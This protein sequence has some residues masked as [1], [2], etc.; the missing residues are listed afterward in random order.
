MNNLFKIAV[1][2]LSLFTVS[3]NLFSQDLIGGIA[4]EGTLELE[5]NNTGSS[6]NFQV[7]R[8]TDGVWV[9][10]WY[11]TGN[12]SF[13]LY[14]SSDGAHADGYYWTSG[15]GWDNIT[16]NRID[17]NNHET[18][19]SMTAGL[20][21]KRIIY[22]PANST[23]TQYRYEI[24]NNDV[25]TK[26]DLRFF[27]GG[28]TW[29]SGGDNGEGNWDAV[30]DVV[31]VSKTVT[32]T[33]Q[34]V[35]LNVQSES[36]ASYA[37]QSDFY[38]N[39]QNNIEAGSPALDNTVDVVSHDNAL[40]LEWRRDTLSAGVTWSIEVTEWF[41]SKLT[42]DLT[43]TAS[44]GDTISPCETKDITF[45]VE[46]TSGA[47]VSNISLG[48]LIDL[49]GW[50]A[51]VTSP[52]VPF[53]LLAG[54][55]Q[56]V[57]VSVTA[58]CAATVGQVAQNELTATGGVNVA[59][60][61]AYIT[62]VAGVPVP[63]VCGTVDFRADSN[64]DPYPAITPF[65]STMT[66]AD[67]WI[68]LT[69]V[70]SATAGNYILPALH[71]V[72]DAAADGDDRAKVFSGGSATVNSGTLL[73]DDV[74][75]NNFEF[76]YMLSQ[77]SPSDIYYIEVCNAGAGNPVDWE[78]F[79]GSS[80]VSLGSGTEG[81][82][83]G[84]R[85]FGPFSPIGSAT[86]ASDAPLASIAFTDAGYMSFDPALSGPGT[87]DF[88]YYW[89]DGNT[90]S[91]SATKTITVSSPHDA[92]WTNPGAIC[93]A[94]AAVNLDNEITGDAG[95]VFTGTG[96]SGTG[97]GP[98]PY[99]F[100]PS[101]GTQTVFYTVTTAV[102]CF[103]TMSHVLTVTPLNTAAAASSSPTL[104][105]NTAL[106]AITIATTGA[107][108]IANDGT[109][110]ANGLPAGVSA[111]WAGNTITIS[112]T[113]TTA[114]GSP[115]GYSILLT[116]GCGTVNATGT[117]TVTPDNTAAVASSSPSLCIN[118]ALTAI[119]IATTGATGIANDGV[120]GA[121]GLPAGVSAT[122]SGNTIT[123]SG[124][125]T[126]A[127]GS[128]FGYSIL[129]T[130]GCGTVNATG[131]ITVTPDNTAAAASSSPT[132]CVNTALTAIT[133]ATTGATGIANDGVAGANGL[134]AGVSANFSGNTITISGTP[135]TAVGSPFG[136][137]ILL[138]GGCGTVN[139]TGTITVT[140]DNT[141]GVAS[142]SPALCVN[143]AISPVVTIA[144]TG[145]T[146]IANDG[147]D[148][149]NGLPTGVSATFS[150]NT[151]TISGTPSTAVGSPFGYSILLTGGCGTVNAT[152]TITVTP[153]N[154]AAV[155]SSSPILC[156]NTALTAI[157][158]ATTG[159]TG[160]ANDGVAGANGLPAG[161]SA[162][163][164]GNTITI[165][166]T[167][168]TGVGS[169]FGYSILLT[170][171][172]GTVNAIGTITVTPDNTAGVASS[173]PALCVNTAISPAVTIATTG[174]TGIAND[175][176]D[177]ANG[178]PTGVSATFSGNTITISG[179]PSTDVGSPFGYS[180]L[181][182]GGCGTVNA[183][184]TI[185]VTTVNTAAAA[186]SSPTLCVNT[187]LT[188]ITIITAGATGIANDGVD[189]AN[190]LPAGVTATW[191]GNTITISGTPSTAIGS[192]FGYSILLTGGCGTANA[193]GTI[194][195]TNINTA[196]VASSSPTL[197][198]NTALTA[199]TIATTGAT[200]I[201]NDG[202][203]GANGLPAG[204]N[205]TF[206]GN[207]I[208][209]SGTPTTGVG[210]PFG[211]NILLT[212]GCGTVNAT[213]A[214]TVTPENTAGVASIS[215]T[216][217]V[218]TALTAIT[219]ATTGATGIA[220]DG[221]DGANGLPTGV[222]ATFSG[223]TITIS[224][225]PT[226]GVGS[227]FGYNILLTGG[228]GTVNATGT[229]TVTPENTAAAAS[230]SPNL[231][232]N[233][234]LTAI[235]IATT[236]ATGIANDGVDGANGLPAGVNATFS[237]N[238]ITISGTPTTGVGSP[239]GYNILLT[240][241]CGTVNATGTIT[242]TPE[243]TVG[244]ASSSPTLCVNTGLTA[245]TIAT[246]GVT[247]IA[248]D[249]VDGANGLPTGVSA[250]FSGNTI[251]ISGTPTTGVGSPFGYSILLTGGCGTVSA[252]G[253]IMVTPDNTAGVASSSPTLCVNTA[254][255]AITI[256]TTGATGI[257]NDG[258]DGAN[259]LPAGV[260]ATWFGG[261]I[262]IS[263][264]P[265]T[266][267]GSPFAYSIPLT[268]G[269]GS[270]NATGT[271]TV[272]PQLSI[273]A[274]ADEPFCLNKNIVLSATS[275]G[276]GT[277][278][279]YTDVLG[280]DKVGEGS[281]LVLPNPGNGD[282]TY[283]VNEVGSS[284]P[285]NMDS[286]DVTISG[287]V[288]E[289]NSNLASGEIPLE[290]AFDANRSLGVI[291]TY[292]WDFGNGDVSSGPNTTT[293]FDEIGIYTI[294]LIVTVGNCPDTASVEVDAFGTSTLLIPN[295]FT[296]NGDGENDIFT[297]DGVNLESI[298]CEIFNRWGQKVFSWTNF[299]GYWD[300][301]TLAGSEAPAGTY[302]F[303]VKAVG[304]DG[305]EYF[306]KGTVSLVK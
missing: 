141:A 30:N 91:D 211:Y 56:S 153:D 10:Q 163:F 288:A 236:G 17:N 16:T 289:I 34:F 263:G 49:A 158:I 3:L 253:T 214:I 298:N 273:L 58:S 95:G 284:C 82:G 161:V 29:L 186:S 181:L 258:V 41:D 97:S 238:T 301:R 159:A 190:G 250:T 302:F 194:T 65:P 18:T 81:G 207:T 259:G 1:L 127:V 130:G 203:N 86:W 36:E 232:V 305:Q 296:P 74:L 33:G 59:D 248:N 223:N 226:T 132:L 117:I 62:V 125:P 8:Y 148:G 264:T 28:D 195:V 306:K 131:T 200:G 43:V 83:A 180:I 172:C 5:I 271:F 101:V 247:G 212:G 303:I 299:N 85:R 282:Y 99:V 52:V 160:I 254:L 176:V 174:A 208:T 239:F 304:L 167:P 89:D 154:T 261:T 279:W 108:G 255:T 165:T 157:T 126:T 246:T 241:G 278:S 71:F 63:I 249:G 145:A 14:S 54:A 139:A 32:A 136:Y 77:I 209:I 164:S 189:G 205:A 44:T 96:V 84:C 177:G 217:C 106:T 133:I 15:S 171:G 233:T 175:G 137:S 274:M 60:D 179:T 188:D 219:I 129:L 140:P 197:C 267:L 218:N 252:I 22:Y 31:G 53:S 78:V 66:C 11:G 73:Y 147:V 270:V 235:T 128:P 146:G 92:S 187:A 287:V 294:E 191:A 300:G 185:I 118:T 21:V 156:V 152:G 193:T 38:S 93:I 275:S 225:T 227:P 12:R 260:S 224:G 285:S 202:V 216:L 242:I 35:A 292:S 120:V 222:S 90:C 290:V 47:T 230:S 138:T 276:S 162:N 206:S 220:N 46:N 150:G 151:I 281:P 103:D 168:T 213:G 24:T 143:T 234:A 109:D 111:T 280:L 221:V 135:S 104:C 243:S 204:V 231:C 178:L 55:S 142:S 269:C 80:L 23:T 192:P 272:D 293:T 68:Y 107:T 45:T 98:D 134:P 114:V 240:G 119:T 9:K 184:G 166:G 210:S 76:T 19:A 87:F 48:Q 102:A 173:S 51:I 61:V 4:A 266:E 42:S 268:G 277:I 110:G 79:D 57:T 69:G 37:H 123:I 112:G 2:I 113:P 215:P 75:T 245:I 244:V 70:D 256:T 237:G 198:V 257:A 183:T 169:P 291:T 251:T 67:D 228:C 13:K 182:T 115:F 155:A 88:T 7:Y 170:G 116:G 6:T 27:I 25:T 201:A 286:V 144:T 40:A 295:V 122:F 265:T 262:T 50:T 64:V 20:E 229:I 196:G 283:Y 124:T 297:I 105:I 26:N 149:A 72:F 39:V 100:D 199:I 94:D 121:N